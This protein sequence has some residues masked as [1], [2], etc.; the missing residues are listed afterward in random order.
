MYRVLSVVVI[1]AVSTFA[2]GSEIDLTTAGAGSVT[3]PAGYGWS[4]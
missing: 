3:I 2:Y 4:N 1:L